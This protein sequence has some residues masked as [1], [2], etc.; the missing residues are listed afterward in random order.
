[1]NVTAPKT[2]IK[3]ASLVTSSLITPFQ[4]S[5]DFPSETSLSFMYST[6]TESES[7]KSAKIQP[8]KG[9]A[10]PAR[11]TPMTAKKIA[12]FGLLNAITFMKSERALK[13]LIYSSTIS[14]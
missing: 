7:N 2:V 11:A 14:S 10:T 5:G 6:G 12:I 3:I 1:M 9:Y 4:S 13:G 8:K